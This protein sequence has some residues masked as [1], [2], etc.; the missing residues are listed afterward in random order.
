MPLSNKRNYTSPIQF[1]D[2]TKGMREAITGYQG[3]RDKRA[4]RET[5]LEQLLY[6]R[7]RD[8][9]QDVIAADKVAYSRGRDDKSD[10]L[11]SQKLLYDQGQDYKKDVIEGQKLTNTYNAAEATANYR[12]DTL[13]ENARYHKATEGDFSGFT[14]EYGKTWMVDKN[15]GKKE[16]INTGVGAGNMPFGGAGGKN[17]IMVDSTIPDGYGGQTTVKTPVDKRT[18]LDAEGNQPMV[19]KQATLS[20]S[21]KDYT[22]NYGQS[23]TLNKSIRDSF[24]N[25]GIW[26]G[27]DA[28]TGPI[29]AFFGSKEGGDQRLVKQDLENLRL[30]AT[31]KLTGVL[32]DQD[33]KIILDTIP[34]IDD[35]PNIAR[36]K[37]A[38]VEKSIAAADANQFNRLVKSNPNAVKDIATGMTNGS[39]PVPPGYNLQRNSQTGQ[40]R[41]VPVK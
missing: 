16:E 31:N 19:T 29:G 37:L 20:Q 39:T 2:S 4:D 38:K 18:G 28:M 25:K 14:D 32:S 12:A 7:N 34:T 23:E 24:S 8:A 36:K 1:N 11:A 22:K 17:I 26:G 5:A 35:Q 21:D 27:L 33:M 10:L 6:S 3:M 30:E 40:Y 15:T 13:K 41:L 9:K